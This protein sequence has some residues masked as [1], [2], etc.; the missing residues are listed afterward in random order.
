MHVLDVDRAVYRI[1]VAAKEVGETVY[2]LR[3]A[4]RAGLQGAM[5]LPHWTDEGRQLVRLLAA[6]ARTARGRVS[7][8][9]V[10]NGP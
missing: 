7:A 8:T 4:Q 9:T 6:C 10:E 3:L 1:A 5:E 2:W